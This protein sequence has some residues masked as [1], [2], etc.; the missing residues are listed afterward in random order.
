MTES[1]GGYESGVEFYTRQIKQVLGVI[2]TRSCLE[3]SDFKSAY[4]YLGL[5][6]EVELASLK[7]DQ[8]KRRRIY[9][10]I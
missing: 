1:K 9:K 10:L 8:L 3:E 7:L 5:V 6:E 2:N 4:D